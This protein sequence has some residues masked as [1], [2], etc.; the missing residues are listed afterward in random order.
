MSVKKL[1]KTA[2]LAAIAALIFGIAP[3]HAQTATATVAVGTV[4]NAV[5]VNPVT[6]KIYV[7][8]NS[9]GNVTV[10]DGA[11]NNTATVAVGTGPFAAAV[12]PVTNKIYV[13]STGTNNMTVIDGATNNTST[14]TVGTSPRSVA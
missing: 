11:T 8:N 7:A 12:N 10:I 14:V 6:N 1:L 9:S 2:S 13:V 5:A 3:L 4:P